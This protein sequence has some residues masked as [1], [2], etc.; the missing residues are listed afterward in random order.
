MK[1]AHTSSRLRREDK[2]SDFVI[3]CKGREWR[4]HR[5]ILPANSTFFEK[6]CCGTFK[7]RSS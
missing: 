3:S 5:L 1:S 4:V 7:V 6:L 2:F